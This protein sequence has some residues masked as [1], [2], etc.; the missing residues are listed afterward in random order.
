MNYNEN[1][2]NNLNIAEISNAIKSVEISVPLKASGNSIN[3]NPSIAHLRDNAFLISFYTFR[4]NC[5]HPKTIQPQPSI[6]DEYHMWYEGPGSNFYWCEGPYGDKGTG[7]IIIKITNRNVRIHQVLNKKGEGVDTRL[8]D[9]SIGIVATYTENSEIQYDNEWGENRVN[10]GLPASTCKHNC[11]A[12]YYLILKIKYYPSNDYYE[13]SNVDS[14]GAPLCQKLQDQEKN[15]SLFT[16]DDNIYTSYWLAPKHTVITLNKEQCQVFM[17]QNTNIFYRI[18]NYYKDTVMFSLSTPALLYGVNEMLG[19]GHVKIANDRLP[20]NTAAYNFNIQNIL[21]KHPS[22]NGTW[23][24]FL[25]TFD[26]Y[27]FEIIRV[28]PAFYPPGTSY[29]IVFPEGLVFYDDNY[30]ISYG[31]GDIKMK[32]LFI[33]PI[34]IDQL[35]IPQHQIN[36]EYIFVHLK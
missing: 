22:K 36:D 29:G 12:I 35:L 13:I 33:P 10:F 1:F 30:I 5:G 9:T 19:V 24:M 28:S 6:Q 15:W 16:V 2:L 26:P 17:E 3:F 27:T 21:P 14:H 7:Y 31:E 8:T 11:Y 34:I 4:R 23:M 32:L 20:I 18:K 25:Y